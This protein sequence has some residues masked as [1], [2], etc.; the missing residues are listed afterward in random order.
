MITTI[1]RTAT[2]QQLMDAVDHVSTQLH[3]P[4]TQVRSEVAVAYICKHFEQGDY[5]GWDGWIEMREA[6]QKSIDRYKERKEST[7]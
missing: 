7:S 1:L 3:L 2:I 5:S 4:R 6:D